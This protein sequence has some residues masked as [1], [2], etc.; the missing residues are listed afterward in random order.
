M[1]R[2]QHQIRQLPYWARVAFAARCARRVLP[3]FTRFWSAADVAHQQALERAIRL[4]EESASTAHAADGLVDAGGGAVGAAS[5]AGSRTIYHRPLE[6]EPAPKAPRGERAARIAAYAAHTAEWA[7]ELVRLPADVAAAAAELSR[8]A[9]EAAQGESDAA[10]DATG[11]AS[12]VAR[13]TNQLSLA[14][15]Q[16]YWFAHQA[17]E[18]A[19]DQETLQGIEQDLDQL[20]RVAQ[21]GGWGA[22]TPV[23]PSVFCPAGFDKPGTST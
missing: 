19:R 20:V 23:P 22:Q 6:R 13:L 2:I 4:V 11:H 18:E 21:E 8:T 5:A 7:V 17:A 10:E 9:Q 12:E 16:T 14:T 15:F 1:E 3:L